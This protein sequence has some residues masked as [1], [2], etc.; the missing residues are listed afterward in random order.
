MLDRAVLAGLAAETRLRLAAQAIRWVTGADY[1]PRFAAL[2]AALAQVL[3]ERRATLADCVLAPRRGT[4]RIGRE[5]RAALAAPPVAP[6]QVWDGRWR[7]DGPGDTVR[8]L[9]P[10]V[11]DCPGARATGLPRD[12]LMASPALWDGTCLVAAPLAGLGPQVRLEPARDA[13]GFFLSLVSH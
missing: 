5:L 8:A 11:A 3:D 1:R 4:V 12:T 10:A 2:Q 9:G 13:A 6:G 7:L